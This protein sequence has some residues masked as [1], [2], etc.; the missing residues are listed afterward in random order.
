MVLSS[1]EGV[2]L[3]KMSEIA[4]KMIEIGINNFG[5]N[6]LAAISNPTAQQ[7]YKPV[8]NNINPELAELRQQVNVLTKMVQFLFLDRH[9]LRNRSHSRSQPRSRNQSNKNDL[10][11]YHYKLGSLARKCIQ[12]FTFNS[13]SENDNDRRQ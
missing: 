13:S 8:V 1:S 3:T 6:S 2:D 7:I 12:P 5:S 10:C 4:D 9:R 11:V